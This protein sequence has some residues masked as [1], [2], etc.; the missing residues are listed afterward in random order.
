MS[1]NSFRYSIQEYV[2]TLTPD[3]A[4]EQVANL[5]RAEGLT[6]EV[7]GRVVRSTRVP[8]AFLSFDPAMYSK[9]NLVG[10]NPF[11][12]FESVVVTSDVH[13]SGARLVVTLD[14]RRLLIFWGIQ[15]L[16]LGPIA[17]RAPLGAALACLILVAT[18]SLV[19]WWLGGALVRS[20]VSAALKS[21]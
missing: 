17:T 4:I 15:W 13:E 18:G 12:W 8:L 10:F 14:R 1:K 7:D 19:A 9:R 21:G 20:E 5:L 6:V 11:V 3:F 16:A 2:A